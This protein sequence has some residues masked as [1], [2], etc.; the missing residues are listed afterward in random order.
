MGIVVVGSVAFDDVITPSG[1]NFNAPGGSATFFSLS[2][3][4]FTRVKL[5]AVCGRDFP[6]KYIRLFKKRNIDTDGLEI[7]NGLTFRWKGSYLNDLNAA[8]TI[9]TRLNLF[10]D[11]SPV[12]PHSYRNERVVFLA[13][14]NPGL[15]LDVL[16][17]VKKPWITAADTISL[18]ISTERKKMLE[19][20]KRIDI[21]II[22]EHEA[23]QLTGVD[24]L[25]KAATRIVSMGPRIVIIKKGEHGLLALADKKV[26]AYPAYLVKD[27]LDPTGAG[28]T[29]AGGFLGYIAKAAKI[30]DKSIRQAL[31]YGSVMASFNVE[32]FD[33]RGLVR[34]DGPAIEKRVDNF[35]RIFA[36]R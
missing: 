29:F 1:K 6:E 26:I 24:N 4:Y 30:D 10:K 25:L 31:V 11:F 36:V 3:S 27:V 13:N 7:K 19:V 9:Y 28:D 15:Q 22:N 35:K 2:A 33:I 23:R 34:L 14:I 18:W 5:V 32:D 17:Q 8:Q 12:L 16:K 21:Y 20:L